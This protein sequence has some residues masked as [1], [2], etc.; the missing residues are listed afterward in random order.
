MS[1]TALDREEIRPFS[2]GFSDADLEDLRTRIL[3]TRWPDRETVGDRSQGTPLAAIQH[4]AEYWAAQYDWRTAEK[5]LQS[6]PHFL[7]EVEHL[8]IH[9][10]HVRSKHEDALPL[11]LT[12][13]WPGSVIQQMKIIDPLV[14]PTAYGADAADAFHVVMPSLP[15]YGFSGKPTTA[16]WGP[17]RIAQAW[18]EV[19]KRLGYTRFAAQGGD[20]GAIITELMGVQ[21][22]PGLVGLHTNM[23]GAVPPDIDLALATG[24]PVPTGTQLTEAEQAA[25][26]Q[27]TSMYAH[28]QYAYTMASLP[29]SLMA[30]GDSPVGLAAFMLDPGLELIPH[31]FGGPS[32][33]L[34]RDEV[35]DNITFYWLTNTAISAARLYAEN[36]ISFFGAKGIELPVA[37]SVFPNELYSPPRSWVERAYPN[38]IHY[39]QLARGGHFPAWEQPD[40]FVEEIRAGFRPLRK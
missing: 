15:G 10:I 33:G 2:F 18:A 8:D 26:D 19:M 36:K 38:L 34:T 13:G 24:R 7:T 30:L 14:N 40:L 17:E 27:L 21:A 3:A 37:V 39:N 6:L 20:W 25:V 9:F 1:T 12:H 5:R 4:L 35:L 23:A 28:V 11:I 22:P 29:Q 31:A 32:D 16:G